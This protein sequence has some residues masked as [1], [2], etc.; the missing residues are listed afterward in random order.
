MTLLAGMP[1]YAWRNLIVFLALV[2]AAGV[3]VIVRIRRSKPQSRGF[4]LC[5]A[6][7]I[8]G[9]VIGMGLFALDM[10]ANYPHVEWI[11]LRGYLFYSTAISVCVAAAIAAFVDLPAWLT[12]T[13]RSDD[14]HVDQMT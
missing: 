6:A 3:F 1:A 10:L 8:T 7:A 2:G 5:I 11:F 13:T 9:P 4:P 14:S 12:K